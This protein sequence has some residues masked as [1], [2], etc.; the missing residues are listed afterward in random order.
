MK[1]LVIQT[2]F[3]G[4]VVLATPVLEQL[5]RF[6]PDAQLDILLRKGNEGLFRGHPFLNHVLIWDKKQGKYRNLLRLIR[7]LRQSRYDLVINCQRFGAS[8]L[9]TALSGARQSIGF[10]KN[11]FSR[12]FSKRVAH[13]IGDTHEVQRNL[14]LLESL[15]TVAETRPRLYPTAQDEAKTALLRQGHTYIC[16]A[17]TSV[18][19]TKQWPAEKWTALIRRIPA[20][21]RVFLLGGPADAQACA[22]IAAAS[23]HPD[24]HNLCGHLSLL[25]S[26]A[27]MRDAAMNY[28]NDSAPMHFASSVNA[29]VCAVY[30]STVPAFGFGPLSEQR[31][32][33]ETP[34][35][36]ECRPCGLHGY[37]ACPKGHFACAMAIDPSILP[38]PEAER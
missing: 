35:P 31:Y 25:E 30:C 10:D 19:F 4:D 24:V 22:D 33:I 16:I 14:A 32:V 2:A 38:I 1:V 17:P 27:L 34:Q 3:I 36:L 37:K 8:G 12:L 18:W 26:V 20:S 15:G 5:H 6:Y 13:K 23:A 28:V 7:A 11:P 21:V 9:L 29:P